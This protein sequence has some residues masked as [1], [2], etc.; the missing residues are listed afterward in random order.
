MKT[1]GLLGKNISYSLS[2]IMHNAVF[3]AL[4]I[5]GEYKIFDI[6]EN[7]LDNFFKKV[8]EGKISGCNVTIPYKEKALEF[9]DKKDERVSDIGALNTVVSK[10]G[11]LSGYNTDFDGF[12]GTLTGSGKE[13]LGFDEHGKSIFIFGAGGAA[14]TIVFSLIGKEHAVK[15]IILADVDIEKANTLA[16]SFVE[17]QKGDAIISVAQDQEQYNEFISKSDLLINATPCGMKEG[18]PPLFDYR[19]IHEKLYVLDLIYAV[20]TPLLKEAKLRAAKAINGL[21]ML[22]RQA[23]ESFKYW[24]GVEVSESLPIMEKAISEKL[25]K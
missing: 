12:L 23:A 14:K 10:K 25:K 1:Y 20:N 6:D 17:K 21:E 4:K 24:T 13:D 7:A 16:G 8:K 9:V 11:V 19:Y 22:I 5:G 2:P 15:K 3:K 18:D